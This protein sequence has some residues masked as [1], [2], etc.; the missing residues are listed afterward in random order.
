[1]SIDRTRIASRI[2]D[3]ERHI[4]IISRIHDQGIAAYCDNYEDYLLSQRCLEIVF[5]AM[6]DIASH[7]ISS[8]F[9]EVPT[10]YGDLF[11]ILGQQGVLPEE[12]GLKL[13]RM[14]GLRNLLVHNYGHLE[15]ERLYEILDDTIKDAQAFIQLIQKFMATR[16]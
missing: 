5:Q 11:V 3:I 6:I 15:N 7:I 8:E 14:A 13:K 12:F 1:M 4:P 2:R 9:K 10:S 16:F